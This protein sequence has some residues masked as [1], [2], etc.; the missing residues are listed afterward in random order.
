ME[1]PRSKYLS[2]PLEIICKANKGISTHTHSHSKW[3]FQ[4]SVKCQ[5][6]SWKKTWESW[7]V[8]RQLDAMP[9]IILWPICTIII[10]HIS[11]TCKMG[12]LKCYFCTIS[13]VHL[14]KHFKS[15][16]INVYIFETFLYYVF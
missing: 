3:N 7:R 13:L 8:T 15:C 14:K 5:V 2:I 6:C 4:N 16:I 1:F 9:W 10:S 12:H 11:F